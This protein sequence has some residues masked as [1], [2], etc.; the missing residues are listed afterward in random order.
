MREERTEMHVQSIYMTCPWGT[1]WLARSGDG[2]G[3]AWAGRIDRPTP[4]P[5]PETARYFVLV[6]E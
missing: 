1:A 6:P 4:P 2:S 3:E 5:M